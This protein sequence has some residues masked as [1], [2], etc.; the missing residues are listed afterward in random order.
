MQAFYPDPDSAVLTVDRQTHRLHIAISADG[1][2]YVGDRWQWWTKGMHQAWLTM[3][4]PGEEYASGSG[5]G[6]HAP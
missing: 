1:A 2:R 3:L 6:C 5:V 4:K